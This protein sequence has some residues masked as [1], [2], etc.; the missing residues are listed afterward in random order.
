MLNITKKE[1]PRK[2]ALFMKTITCY[3]PEIA[4]IKV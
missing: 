3:I 1:L 4:R 2:A